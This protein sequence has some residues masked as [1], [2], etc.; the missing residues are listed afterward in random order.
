[1]SAALTVTLPLPPSVNSLFANVAGRGRIR[2]TAY[3]SWAHSAHYSIIAQAPQSR[4]VAP[5]YSVDIV[6]DTKTRRRF[7]LDNR[8]KA[9]FDILVTAGVMSDDADVV[10]LCA[11]RYTMCEKDQ[12]IVT[13]STYGGK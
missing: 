7:D 10:T 13:V 2:T 11:A 4:L 3:K 6:I 1:M 5:P 12:C 8:L 9:V